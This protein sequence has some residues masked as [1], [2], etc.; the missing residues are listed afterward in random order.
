[1]EI[2]YNKLINDFVQEVALLG[3]TCIF[4][5]ITPEVQSVVHL[6]DPQLKL[7]HIRDNITGAYVML[8]H[9]HP[10]HEKI[11]KYNINTVYRYSDITIEEVISSLK[12]M[13][14]SEGFVIQF[15]NGDMVKAKTDWY[16]DRLEIVGYLHER[17]I[18][19][20]ALKDNLDDVK[21]SIIERGVPLES[22]NKVETRFKNL[23]LEISTEVENIYQKTKHLERKEFA[24]TNKDHPYF[25]FIMNTYLGKQSDI[26]EWYRLNK[27]KEEFSLRSLLPPT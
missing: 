23:I 26:K 6:P 5:F 22:I 17:G 3:M 1:M 16:L 18:A 27:L 8:D 14:H 7:L 2:P 21:A 11:K 12:T 25:G 13:A 9:T 24:L 20:L 19:L 10:V 15:S 4:E